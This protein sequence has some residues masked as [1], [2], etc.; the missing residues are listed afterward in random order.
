MAGYGSLSKVLDVLEAA[1]DPERNGGLDYIA[2]PSFTAADLYLGA[3]IGF[4]L[5]FKTMEPSPVFVAYGAKVNGRPA[6]VRA[7]ALDDALA[8]MPAG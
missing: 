8:P 7:R 6:A 2:G 5:M 4:G 1:L 3:Q